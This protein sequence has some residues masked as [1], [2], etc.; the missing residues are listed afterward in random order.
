MSSNEWLKTRFDFDQPTLILSIIS[1]CISIAILIPSSLTLYLWFAGPIVSALTITFHMIY[2]VQRHLHLRRRRDL[3]SRRQ[4]ELLLL[5]PPAYSAWSVITC[6]CVA[7]LWGFP[8]GFGVL[9]FNPTGNKPLAVYLLA[10]CVIELLFI[11]GVSLMLLGG[12]RQSM[13]QNLAP[14]VQRQTK[15]MAEE[16][17]GSKF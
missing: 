2:F 6:I 7:L 9:V 4:P 3:R 14:A 16:A 17:E 1:T 5:Q 8:L 11:I 10:M 12:R 13:R 15:N